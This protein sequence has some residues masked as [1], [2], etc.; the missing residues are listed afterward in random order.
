M[1]STRPRPARPR[2][3]LALNTLD[4]AYG[5]VG[6]LVI[7]A[8]ALIAAF[9][10]IALDPERSADLGGVDTKLLLL[11]NSVIA[12]SGYEPGLIVLLALAALNVLGMTM[13][14]RAITPDAKLDGDELDLMRRAG[15]C[16][17]VI[18]STEY[19]YDCYGPQGERE[20]F[21]D[22]DELRF[23]VEHDIGEDKTSGVVEP[24][25]R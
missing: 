25:R 7:I 14:I 1:A 17:W 10:L 23:F 24:L 2:W 20:Q 8:L 12:A 9:A 16:G 6:G 5:I 13:I 3:I 21:R 11:T 22:V 19:L 15:R 18:E 4:R